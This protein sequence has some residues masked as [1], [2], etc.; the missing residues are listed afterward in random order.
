MR[1]LHIDN[2]RNGPRDPDPHTATDAISE[3]NFAAPVD[4]VTED[5]LSRHIRLHVEQEMIVLYEAE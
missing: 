1:P 5:G 2:S 3:S 4:L